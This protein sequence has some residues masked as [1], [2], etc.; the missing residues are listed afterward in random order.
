VVTSVCQ[1]EKQVRID[2]FLLFSVGTKTA[3]MCLSLYIL[4]LL[5]SVTCQ[6]KSV[7]RVLKKDMAVLSKVLVSL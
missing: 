3:L 1:K 2:A 6:L 4:N 7:S 5:F